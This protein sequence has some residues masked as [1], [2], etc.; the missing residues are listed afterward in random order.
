MF[1]CD[2][3]DYIRN[4]QT[5]RGL[6]VACLFCCAVSH[7][8]YLQVLNG[9]FTSD[10][11][12]STEGVEDGHN[13]GN[14]TVTISR[15]NKGLHFSSLLM[16][17]YSESEILKVN[18]FLRMLREVGVP[19]GDNHRHQSNHHDQQ[20]RP[21]PSAGNMRRR[22]RDVTKTKQL[23]RGSKATHTTG[24]RDV[25]DHMCLGLDSVVALF[26]GEI[27]EPQDLMYLAPV[28][29]YQLTPFCERRLSD[30]ADHSSQHQ[31][32]HQHRKHHHHHHHQNQHGI[33]NN[34]RNES[35]SV[36]SK[37]DY[38]L[39]EHLDANKRNHS[40]REHDQHHSHHDGH[41]KHDNH[42]LKKVEE[43]GNQS[44]SHQEAEEQNSHHEKD[45][46]GSHSAHV[47]HVNRGQD[48]H[49]DR[50]H[51]TASAE[52]K[53]YHSGHVHHVHEGVET[54]SSHG[55]HI[56]HA[57]K[58]KD[59]SLH[60]D[61]IDHD[62]TD[63]DRH[64]H[65]DNIHHVSRDREK[66]SHGD[67]I[68]HESRDKDKHLHGDHIHHV[69]RDREK[70]FHGDHIQNVSRN[71]DKHLHGDH[72]H[73]VSRD[74]EKHFHG[75]HIQNVSRNKDKHLHGD[76]IDHVS[77]D[78][79]RHLHGDHIHHV[80]R[81]REKHFHGDHIQNVSRNKDKHLHGAHVH[82]TSDHLDHPEDNKHHHFSQSPLKVW[83][84]SILAVLLISLVGL[85][86]VV[87]IPIMRK[88][89]YN[90]VLQFLVAVAVGALTGDALL[91]LLPHA[92]TGDIHDNHKDTHEDNDHSDHFDYHSNSLWMGLCGMGGLITF[93]T[94]ERLLRIFMERK[95][96]MK[97][98]KA[99]S[100]PSPQVSNTGAS[101]SV[102]GVKLSAHEDPDYQECEEMMFNVYRKQRLPIGA[103]A[104]SLLSM[105]AVS[106]PEISVS[107]SENQPLSE[108]EKGHGHSHLTNELPSSVA[109][110]A[111]MVILG[112]G[113]HNFSDG[114]ALGAGFANSITGGI[115]TTIAI[116]CHE[117]PHEIGDFAVLLQA[118]MSVKQAIVYNCVS[119]LLCFFGMVIGV[120]I[121]NV[122]QASLWIFACIAGTFL[123]IAL[124][125][126]LPELCVAPTKGDNPYCILGIQLLGILVGAS[127]MAVIAVFEHSLIKLLDM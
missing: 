30:R 9:T 73:H 100:P 46:Q 58:H 112:D 47:H 113:I 98:K 105:T 57:S 26:G 67:H 86:S 56:H 89:F 50:S 109:T 102:V 1:V 35:S 55:D 124:V 114:L 43:K 107:R 29:L 64:L 34:K 27:R 17:L 24:N 84:S 25:K 65:G 31:Q 41:G 68:H 42:R 15:R 6:L 118:G 104:G 80:S 16:S 53:R 127:I 90:Y 82:E 5:M 28:I 121:G 92:M 91:H 2:H 94:M 115:S 66:D 97:R 60:D 123:Y 4:A 36:R 44:D 40:N 111:W 70:H 120:L 69:S 37:G 125:D 11:N 116:F 110:I 75:D 62:S 99:S 38:S 39:H 122:G 85:G 126:M 88:V 3:M 83:G 103:C 119:S 21:E 12:G 48:H 71:K 51:N 74:R 49:G 96:K 59:K 52:V 72:M 108:S 18:D 93:F 79:D 8:P 61:H 19:L 101:D 45:K 23:P 54:N 81:D 20:R 22:E 78:K 32:Q 106:H 95:A 117:L 87:I 63:K 13:H 33:I 77:T 10:N 14:R 76:H 7:S